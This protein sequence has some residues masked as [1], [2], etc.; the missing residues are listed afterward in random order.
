MH[1]PAPVVSLD[2]SI[3]QW[4]NIIEKHE[5]ICMLCNISSRSRL[6]CNKQEATK[7]RSCHIR[8]KSIQCVC[9]RVKHLFATVYAD[10]TR[11]FFLFSERTRRCRTM[12]WCPHYARR[13]LLVRLDDTES[14]CHKYSGVYATLT[15]WLLLWNTFRVIFTK[16]K[17]RNMWFVH[18]QTI[19]QMPREVSAA[20]RRQKCR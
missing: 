18:K 7:M 4:L 20:V 11:V 5:V 10:R 16:V 9:E 17:T 1:R 19:T 14:K 8:S 2:K 15:Y 13:I 12:R 6:D 3:G